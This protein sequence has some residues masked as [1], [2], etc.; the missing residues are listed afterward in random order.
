MG[1]TVGWRAWIHSGTR[2]LWY[3][4]WIG[5][6]TGRERRRQALRW[7]LLWAIPLALAAFSGGA[8]GGGEPAGPPNF[9]LIVTDDQ[10]YDTTGEYMPETQERIFDEGVT[11]ANAF[12]TTPLCCPSRASILTGK[13]A[14]THGVRT[15]DDALTQPTFVHRLHEAGY[16]TGQ[17]GKYLNSYDFRQPP[18]PEFDFWVVSHGGG[19]EYYNASLNVN[20]EQRRARFYITHVL[21]SH[22]EQFLEEATALDQPFLLIFAPNAPHLPALPAPENAQLY[23]ELPPYR[24]PSHNEPDVSDKPA[25]L[26]NTRL[27]N[28]NEQEELDRLRRNQLR[29]LKTVDEVVAALL[30]RLEEEGQLDNT[31]VMFLSDNGHFWGEHRL[32]GK[33]YPYEQSIRVPYGLRYP[34]LAPEGEIREELVA[35]IDIAPT[36]YELAGLPIPEEVDG[37]SLVSL[38]EGD[39]SWRD[40]LLLEAWPGQ[41]HYSAV[42]TER[43]VYVETDGDLP[44]LYDLERDPHQLENAVDDPSYADVVADLRR[45]L[46]RLLTPP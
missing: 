1:S 33:V 40:E 32:G 19:S 41:F 2:L 28:E 13:Y 42:R 37:R 10:R 9:L 45:R 34:K 44:E 16:Y 26:Q 6:Q 17:I 4:G 27:L 36:I 38:L 23:A 29:S 11:F 8:C 7:L 5:H 14:H 25:W 31:V 24:P 30:D 35:N 15:N 39:G 46:A 18:R 20:G 12:V 43:Y 21:Q 3:A 22:A